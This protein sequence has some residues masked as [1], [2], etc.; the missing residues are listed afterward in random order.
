MVPLPVK[1]E[2]TTVSGKAPEV[3]KVVVTWS[4][5]N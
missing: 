5:K 3:E 4:S 2:G 1:L